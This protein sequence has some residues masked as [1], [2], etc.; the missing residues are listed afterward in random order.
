MLILCLQPKKLGNTAVGVAGNAQGIGVADPGMDD[1]E[2][3]ADKIDAL[4]LSQLIE[5]RQ[6]TRR[7]VQD[8][9]HIVFRGWRIETRGHRDSDVKISVKSKIC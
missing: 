9:I 4:C 1:S 6:R 7:I 2:I 5:G 3:L 8:K